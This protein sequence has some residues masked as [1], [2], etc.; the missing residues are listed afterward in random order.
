MSPC[1]W[2][3]VGR[4][5]LTRSGTQGDAATHTPRSGRQRKKSSHL[6]PFS[7]RLSVPA[8]PPLGPQQAQAAEMQRA[9]AL[10]SLPPS[11]P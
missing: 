7:Y 9:L 8:C 3:E 5:A 11:L 6:H 10:P 4:R 2:Q 1:T